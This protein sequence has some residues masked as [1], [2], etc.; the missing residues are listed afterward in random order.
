MYALLDA[1]SRI[2]PYGTRVFIG[3]LPQCLH[4]SAHLFYRQFGLTLVYLLRVC[5]YADDKIRSWYK[6]PIALQQ[7]FRQTDTGTLRVVNIIVEI[8][9]KYP[10]VI[11]TAL[12]I[13][14][15]LK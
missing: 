9:V 1:A 3:K 14:I 15:F 7:P 10:Y 12:S 13:Y 11:F 6:Q 8:A 4:L 2:Y 5:T